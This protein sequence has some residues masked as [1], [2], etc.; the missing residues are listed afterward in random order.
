MSSSGGAAQE[1]E[2][3]HT[4]E[5]VRARLDEGAT[6]D[7]LRDLV[8]GGVDGAVTTFAIAAGAVGAGLGAGAILVLGLAN[9]VTRQKRPPLGI[10]R[11]RCRLSSE[12]QTSRRRSPIA[13]S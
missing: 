1:L 13:C 11:R 2:A 12:N 7:Y 8:F 9:P 5:A 3:S 10:P 6:P 4:P